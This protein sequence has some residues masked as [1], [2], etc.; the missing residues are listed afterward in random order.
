MGL[1]D[2]F[3]KDRNNKEDDLIITGETLKSAIQ[4]VLNT[5]ENIAS[6]IVSTIKE[7]S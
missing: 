4:E 5:D 7:K 2:F 6:E 1:F 3:K